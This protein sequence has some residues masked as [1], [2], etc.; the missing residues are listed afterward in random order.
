MLKFAKKSTLTFYG[1]NPY[2]GDYKLKASSAAFWLLIPNSINLPAYL[3]GIQNLK[4]NIVY[5]IIVKAIQAGVNRKIRY[6][7]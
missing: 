2:P 3:T 6:I 1:D 5:N 4:G 7:Y